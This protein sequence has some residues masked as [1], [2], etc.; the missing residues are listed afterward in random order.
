MRTRRG[1][2]N[3]DDRVLGPFLVLQCR[4]GVEVMDTMS[5]LF[6]TLCLEKQLVCLDGVSQR[7]AIPQEVQGSV[8]LSE[9]KLRSD[10]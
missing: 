10:G 5:P 7:P 2:E 3:P 1:R 9:K 6:R 4:L 8:D